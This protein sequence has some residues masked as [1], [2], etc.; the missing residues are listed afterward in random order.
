M[1][2]YGENGGYLYIVSIDPEQAY[3]RLSRK[4]MRWTLE[5]K[6]IPCKEH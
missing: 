1:E 4:V 3:D 5:K 2:R 6:Q